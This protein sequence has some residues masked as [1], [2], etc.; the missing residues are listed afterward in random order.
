[1]IASPD[2]RPPIVAPLPESAGR[3]T[4]ASADAIALYRAW[5]NRFQIP[6]HFSLPDWS[7]ADL[8][9]A[10]ALLSRGMPDERVKSILRLASPQFPRSHADPEDYLRRTIQRAVQ[11]TVSYTASYTAP[12]FPARQTT[13]TGF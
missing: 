2:V 6:Q 13:S 12:P 1:L 7:I 10:K 5:L 4:I 3:Q 9:I 8:W 11:D